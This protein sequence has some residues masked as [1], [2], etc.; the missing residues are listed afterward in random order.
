MLI[1]KGPLFVWRTNE[2]SGMYLWAYDF[3]RFLKLLLEVK[4]RESYVEIYI[5]SS[6]DLQTRNYRH[7]CTKWRGRGGWARP[8]TIGM[9]L[10]N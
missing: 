7:F 8:L 1:P 10:T 4:N 5:F 9:L 6:R 3:V 2:I